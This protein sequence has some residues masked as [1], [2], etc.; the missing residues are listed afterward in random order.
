MRELT[1]AELEEVSGGNHN[2][3][4]KLEKLVDKLEKFDEQV[5]KKRQKLLDKIN[6]LLGNDEGEG[7]T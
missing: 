1:V 5:A 2:T 7:T 3:N 6:K 4:K